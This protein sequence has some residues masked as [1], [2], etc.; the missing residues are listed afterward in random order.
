MK[1]FKNR[2]AIKEHVKN[3]VLFLDYK[4]V[5]IDE[6]VKLGKGVLVGANVVLKGKINVG[7]YAEIF[8]SYIEDS[9]IGSRTIVKSSYI[10]DSEIG[11]KTTVGPF[12]HIRQKTKIGQGCRI[13]NFVEIKES[14]IGD[15]TKCA[16]L[17][18]IGNAK[19][20]K[21]VNVGCG[22]VFANFNGKIK[23][24]TVVG[25]DV[26]IGCNT[27]LVA[28]LTIG[29]GCYIA[30]GTTVTKNLDKDNFCIGR[31]RQ[32]SKLKMQYDFFEDIDKEK[33]KEM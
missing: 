32:E 17:A 8:D 13:G 24:Q 30:A 7:D 23:Q 16:H 19:V 11:D 22:V 21:N 12:S 14:I 26:F 2:R 3:G 5:V 27:N 20:G 33:E 28:P 15:Y 10:I 4:S 6:D 31:V 18:Y 25:N 29:D 9:A 1:N